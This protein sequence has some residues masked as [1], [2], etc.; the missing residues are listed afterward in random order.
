MSV[1]RRLAALAVAATAALGVAAPAHAA[2]GPD[3]LAALAAL[4]QPHA[5]SYAAWDAARRQRDR[6]AQYGFDWRTDYCTASPDRPLGFDFRLACWRHDFG[7]R[8]YRAARAFDATVKRRV[9]D[10]LYADLKRRCATYPAKSQP[11]CRAVAGLYHR[12]VVTLG[13]L[14]PVVPKGAVRAAAR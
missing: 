5:A 12:A 2:T 14:E 13:P 3:R 1:R 9:D 11:V 6:W 4:T 10:A 7:Y 8:N